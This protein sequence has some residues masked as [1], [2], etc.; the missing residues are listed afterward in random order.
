MGASVL[1]GGPMGNYDTE[2]ADN[3]R[4][5]SLL[6]PHFSPRR[7]RAFRPRVDE[8]TAGLLN[9]LA[10]HGPPA[11]LHQALALPLPIQVICELLGVPYADR[12]RFRAWS[13]AV[14][15]VRDRARSGQG[16]GELFGYG[17]QLVA[18]KREQPG[19]DFISRLCA[20]GLGD[21]EIAML[22]MGL[23]FAGHETTVAAIGMGALCLLANPGQLQALIDDPG[24]ITSAVEE[25]L[26]APGRG[27]GGIPRYA[28]TDL[29]I[30]EITVRAGELVLLDNR[31][32][33]HD[34][35]V[36][37]SPD[38]FDITRQGPA[39]L[40]FGHGAHYLPRRPARPHRTAG[41]LLPAAGALPQDAARRPGRAAAGAIRDADRRPDR[42]ASGMVEPGNNRSS[43]AASRACPLRPASVILLGRPSA[44]RDEVR[45]LM[46]EQN[47]TLC[48]R[49]TAH[50]ARLP[51]APSR[52]DSPAGPPDHAQ[53]LR[54]APRPAREIRSVPNG[55]A[56]RRTG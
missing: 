43:G 9:D 42:T 18:R 49:C 7:M 28:R 32:A 3:A 40:S 26:R 16:L 5:R 55:V 23:L 29:Q 21:D 48:G 12:E 45:H 13:E 39:H 50:Q 4:L 20:G 15:D 41:G 34:P 46:H 19:D 56:P 11:D 38:R 52:S 8:L 37:P 1:F 6:Q 27:G 2:Q 22:S 31:A 25:I 51:P 53:R 44:C 10:G 54:L 24:Q 17:Q 36:F 14:G 47:G 35:A 33:N 30:G